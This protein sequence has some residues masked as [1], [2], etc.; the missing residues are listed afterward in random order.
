MPPSPI[1][2]FVGESH[3]GSGAG[4]HD[5]PFVFGRKS[6]AV[7]PIPFSTRELGRLMVLRSRLQT[8]LLGEDGY[9]PQVACRTRCSSH[10]EWE[11]HGRML[12]HGSMHHSIGLHGILRPNGWPFRHP[13][14]GHAV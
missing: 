13:P 9:V 14:L 7:A 8:G 2:Q 11:L 10:A 6:H 5:L 12:G 4:D 3:D 1:E